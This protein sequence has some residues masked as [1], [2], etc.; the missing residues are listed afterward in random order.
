MASKSALGPELN[1]LENGFFLFTILF[2]TK[3]T[4]LPNSHF[5][6]AQEAHQARVLYLLY[7]GFPGGAGL[8]K[9]HAVHFRYHMMVVEYSLTNWWHI[10]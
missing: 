4:F 2:R 7:F 1:L 8:A 10:L 5:F 3:S 9:Y 6:A